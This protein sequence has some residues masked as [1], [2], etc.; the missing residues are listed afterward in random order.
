M[1]DTPQDLVTTYHNA[2][3]TGNVLNL[4]R[5]FHKD[6]AIIGVQDGLFVSADRSTFLRFFVSQ[7]ERYASPEWRTVNT[8]WIEQRERLA[9]AC[10]VERISETRSLSYHTMLMTEEGWKFITKSFSGLQEK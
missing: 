2:V 1:N 6:A 9:I 10:F 7:M 8:Q 3:L 5:C 4:E